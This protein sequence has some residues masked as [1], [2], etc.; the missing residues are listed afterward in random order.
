MKINLSDYIEELRTALDAMDDVRDVFVFGG[1]PNDEDLRR[2]KLQPNSISILLTA[3]GGDLLQ[4]NDPNAI[5][6][7]VVFAAYIIGPTNRQGKDMGYS[8]KLLDAAQQVM[9]T[10]KNLKDGSALPHRTQLLPRFLE[11]G[12]M[13]SPI[14]NASSHACWYLVW[15]Q[16]VTLNL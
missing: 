10:I 11:W 7:N 9:G 2:V 6:S 8:P 16:R 13:T 12:E 14:Q 4:S 3:G 5:D 15:E 1:K